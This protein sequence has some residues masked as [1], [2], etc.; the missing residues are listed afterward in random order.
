MQKRIRNREKGTGTIEKKRNR[1][2]L[3]T[4]IGDKS[5]STLL[6]GKDDKPVTTRKD[7]EAAAAL[8]RPVLRARQKEEVALYVASARKLRKESSLSIEKIWETYLAQYRRPDSSE[9]TLKSY[10]KSLNHFIEWLAAEHPEVR[11]AVEITEEIAGEYFNYVWNTKHVT[12]KTFNI[13]RQ[14]LQLIFKH[15]QDVAGLDSNP[16]AIIERKPVQME[17]R[18]PF[19]EEQIK[20][21]FEGF[22]RGF[23]YRRQ[24][25][26]LGPGKKH[27]KV[28]KTLQFKP[29]FQD[30]MRVLLMLCCW[31]GC[32]GQDG[33][34]MHWSNVDMEHRII[35]YIPRKTARQTNN[36]EVSLPLHPALYEALLIAETFRS[37]NKTGEDF[38]IPSVA[39][40]FQRNPGGVQEDVMKIIHC[41]TGCETTA[42]Q[43]GEH[44]VHK[45]NR[46]SLHS[47][48]HTFVS[49]CANAGVPLD[50]V[51]S[52]VG[53]GSTAMT[54]HY[55]HISDEAKG[56]AIGALP[57]LES[58]QEEVHDPD[59][60]LLLKQLSGLSTE[61]L[62]A[63]IVKTNR[64]SIKV[65]N[66]KA[67]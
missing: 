12:G 64:N 28:N 2:Y 43:R 49:F 33:C 38:V 52:I 39:A 50:V 53:H 44:R 35:S 55:A 15:I 11:K 61:E 65:E 48:R 32:R 51:A 63:L 45:A 16:F 31:T 17:S 9:G 21:I 60:E 66:L 47:F 1:F 27:I 59:R 58:A 54:R 23:Y 30:E 29:M 67:G 40:R 42:S 4:R 57:V 46:Y 20:A 19:T 7:A 36:K 24:L 22:E 10:R 13:Y 62:A 18:L 8:L 34:L 3:K 14:A 41:A 6:L 37:R 5:K 56:K 25:T 26:Q